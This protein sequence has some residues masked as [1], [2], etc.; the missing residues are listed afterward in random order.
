MWKAVGGLTATEQSK[1]SIDLSL[2]ASENVSDSRVKE[3]WPF[4]CEFLLLLSSPVRSGG[5]SPA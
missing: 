1:L 4:S 3:Q 2:T 5:R